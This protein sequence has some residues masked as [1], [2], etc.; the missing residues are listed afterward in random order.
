MTWG[1]SLIPRNAGRRGGTER[2]EWGKDGKDGKEGS[3]GRWRRLREDVQMT[4]AT[5]MELSSLE[6][7]WITDENKRRGAGD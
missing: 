7:G 6:V 4:S 1:V 3:T 2:S 5:R